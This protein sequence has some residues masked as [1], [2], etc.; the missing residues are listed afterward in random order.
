MGNNGERILVHGHPKTLQPCM[1]YDTLLTAIW[2]ALAGSESYTGLTATAA[3]SIHWRQRGVAEAAVM[4]LPAR[5]K[6]FPDS[7]VCA[8]EGGVFLVF[9]CA[10]TVDR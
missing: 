3:H 5:K 4:A 7:V 2:R 9:F 8:A 10:V 6:R 1:L